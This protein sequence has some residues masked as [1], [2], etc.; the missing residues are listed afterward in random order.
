MNIQEYKTK[1][2]AGFILRGA[3]IGTDKMTGKKVRTDIRAR[4]KKGVKNELER[5][6]SEFIKNDCVK[7]G[8]NLQTFGEVAEEWFDFYETTVKSRSVVMMRSFLNLYIIPAFGSSKIDKLTT[9]VIQRQVNQ[10]AKNASKPLNGAPKRQKGDTRNFRLLLN[11]TNRI[12]KYAIS[13][14]MVNANPCLTVLVPRLKMEATEKDVKH[15]NK[16]QLNTFFSYL[17]N[18][19]ITW[20][21]NEL[22]ALCRLLVGSG[23]RIG[24]ALALNW[25]DIDFNKRTVSVSKTIINNNT[26]QET[27]KTKTSKRTIILDSK[28]I[29]AV[30]RW[31][32][33]SQSHFMKL[34]NPNQPLAFPNNKG[35]VSYIQTLRT[36]LLRTFDETNLPNIGFHGFR[37]SHASILL[38]AGV[39]YKEIQARLGHSSIKMTMD[40]YSHLE[41]EKETEAVALFEKYAN[42]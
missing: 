22:K 31:K 23:L 12:F 21:D 13:I 35:R 20:W 28:T 38:N 2:S 7:K 24:E 34:G 25:S 27:P 37:H 42:F 11:V 41:Q 8:K 36:K 16:E 9:A 6:K 15:F 18:Q 33:Y 30:Q 4:T 5:L 17:D 32:L 29:T 39:S 19:P 40:T 26:I 10:W 14:G 3:Y 1:S